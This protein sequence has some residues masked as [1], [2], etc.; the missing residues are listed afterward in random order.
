MDTFY[1]IYVNGEFRKTDQQNIPTD[2]PS[3]QADEILMQIVALM[4]N[5]KTEFTQTFSLESGKRMRYPL[6]GSP[7]SFILAYR[8]NK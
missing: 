6:G 5:A 7:W 3:W 1:Q 2:L 4:G 8:K